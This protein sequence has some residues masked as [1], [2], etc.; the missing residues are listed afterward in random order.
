MLVKRTKSR[1]PGTLQDGRTISLSSIPHV[2]FTGTEIIFKVILLPKQL[3]N[4]KYQ[5]KFLQYFLDHQACISNE[6]KHSALH[7]CTFF[8]LK[9]LQLVLAKGKLY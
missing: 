6:Q 5:Q 4:Q 3:Q 7:L 2:P 9:H 1:R 8:I